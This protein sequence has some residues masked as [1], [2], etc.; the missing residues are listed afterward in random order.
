[1]TAKG[2]TEI[3]T[4]TFTPEHLTLWER[5][6]NYAGAQWPDY[7]RFLSRHRDS[8]ALTRANFDAGLKAIGGEK[9]HAELEDASD[10]GGALSLVKVVR[11][12]H[13]AVGWVEWI[14]IHES[15]VEQLEI[16]DKI[17][18]RLEG[19]PVVDENLFSEYETDEANEVWKN[20]YN[21]KDFYL[22]SERAGPG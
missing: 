15:A 12:N 19:Y 4:N 5:P 8:D 10:P 7:Y 16:A 17:L 3:M 14:A 21:P 1:M 22:D 18:G 9:N 6:N 20:C 11:E 13:W 2:N